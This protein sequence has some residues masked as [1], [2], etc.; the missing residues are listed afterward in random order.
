MTPDHGTRP[1][2]Q[3]RTHVVRHVVLLMGQSNMA[4]RGLWRDGDDI[5]VP[6]VQV[7]DGQATPDDPRPATPTRWRPGRHPLH[8][9]EPDKNPVGLGLAFAG[10]YR[11]RH[12]GVE[13]GLVPCA[14]GG[15]PL[16]RL[17][18]GSVLYEDTVRRAHVAARTGR[19]VGVLWHQGEADAASPDDAAGYGDRLARLV[20]DLR[21][22]LATPGLPFVVG[23]LAEDLGRGGDPVLARSVAAVRAALRDL[24]HRDARVGWTST[25]GLE[26]AA[27]GVHFTREA[28][29]ELGGRYET[30]LA[31]LAGG[32]PFGTS[33]SRTDPHEEGV[34]ACRP[35]GSS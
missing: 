17:G 1:A 31:E 34:P 22:R 14:W 13:V 23:D 5:A 11:A 33:P 35:S 21:R 8:L 30:V 28:L 12:P 25:A 32:R 6:G 27:D 16:D 19:L 24:A 3:G 9:N 26:T 20:V 4:G 10:A 7:L 15:Q 2:Q 18:P 29:V